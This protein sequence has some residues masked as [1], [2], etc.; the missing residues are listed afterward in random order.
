MRRGTHYGTSGFGQ[1]G[2]CRPQPTEA[3]LKVRDQAKEG[4]NQSG[5]FDLINEARAARSQ[6]VNTTGLDRSPG[7]PGVF[8]PETPPDWAERRGGRS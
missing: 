6:P 7:D 5:A 8:G 2:A 3:E 1:H 4:G